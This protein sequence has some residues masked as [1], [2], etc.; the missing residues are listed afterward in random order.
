M[1]RACISLG[2]IKC[3]GCQCTIPYPER[4]VVVDEGKGIQR[5]CLGCSLEKG[6]ARYVEEKGQQILT[7]FTETQ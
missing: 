7:I 1:R 2:D 5:L 6:Y 4:Y 3:D